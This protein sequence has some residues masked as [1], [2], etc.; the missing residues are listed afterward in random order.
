MLIK[1]IVTSIVQ[2]ARFGDAKHPTVQEM[3]VRLRAERTLAVP[4]A[5]VR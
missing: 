1:N 4:R 5:S 3:R 2:S